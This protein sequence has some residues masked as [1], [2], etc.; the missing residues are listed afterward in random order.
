MPLC[1]RHLPR[2]R[3]LVASAV[4][5]QFVVLDGEALGRQPGQ[6][7]RTVVHVKDAL[8]FVALEVVVVGMVCGLVPGAVAGKRH[9]GD[10]ALVDQAFQV[11]VDGGLAQP[12]HF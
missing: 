1:A 2:R 6:I 9:D 10:V 3:A 12:G 8:A 4:K 7:A 5:G 11:A